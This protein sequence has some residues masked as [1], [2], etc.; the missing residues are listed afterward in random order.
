MHLIIKVLNVIAGKKPQ[1]LCILFKATST[2]FH[3]W[4]GYFVL[5]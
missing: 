3:I 5:S 2:D 4:P 1:V